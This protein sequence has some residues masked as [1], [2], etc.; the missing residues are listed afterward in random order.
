[1]GSPKNHSQDIITISQTNELLK[2]GIGFI[3][4][5]FAFSALHIYA[6]Q[7]DRLDGVGF[8][9]TILAIGFSI[10]AFVGKKWADWVLI[11]L[12][13]VWIIKAIVMAIFFGVGIMTS[14]EN[15]VLTPFLRLLLIVLA[16][17]YVFRNPKEGTLL[18]IILCCAGIIESLWLFGKSLHEVFQGAKAA[19][20]MGK[21]IMH[22]LS[23]SLSD[24]LVNML[25]TLPLLLAIVHFVWSRKVEEIRVEKTFITL[26]RAKVAPFLES[27]SYLFVSGFG[28]LEIKEILEFIK[29]IKEDGDRKEFTFFPYFEGKF[30]PM[31]IEF[32]ISAD[33][34]FYAPMDLLKRINQKRLIL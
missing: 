24:H 18:F 33:V 6:T 11:G 26:A 4:L 29:E 27:V 30:V 15:T 10:P 9:I 2:Y 28:T 19:M 12:L 1:M 13:S 5:S 17:K 23:S 25:T 20:T 21:A 14:L 31:R 32:T 16:A 34:A 22:A 7:A 8:A 3:L